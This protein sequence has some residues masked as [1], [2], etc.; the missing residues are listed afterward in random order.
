MRLFLIPMC[1]DEW[2]E[3][4]PWAE[5]AAERATALVRRASPDS[6]IR[7]LR[8][9]GYSGKRLPFLGDGGNAA[10]A[11]F[12]W[13]RSE[14]DSIVV[15][16]PRFV[17][18]S[19]WTLDR[20]LQLIDW[21]ERLVVAVRRMRAHIA[22]R[23]RPIRVQRMVETRQTQ[24]EIPADQELMVWIHGVRSGAVAAMG[25]P[26]RFVRPGPVAEFQLGDAEPGL[27]E[28]TPSAE[29]RR[30]T[31]RFIWRPVPMVDGY[32]VYLGGPGDAGGW[33]LFQQGIRGEAEWDVTRGVMVDPASGAP[34]TGR[35]QYPAQYESAGALAAFRPC[36][37][38]ELEAMYLQGQARAVVMDG[39]EAQEVRTALDAMQADLTN[40]RGVASAAE[41]FETEKVLGLKA[42][43]KGDMEGA[44][45]AFCKAHLEACRGGPMTRERIDPDRA[46]DEGLGRIADSRY[47]PSGT[48]VRRP[49]RRR[50]AFVTSFLTD[51]GGHPR[52]LS[53]VLAGLRTERYEVGVF[54]TEFQS[55]E[56]AGPVA[57]SELQALPAVER[58]VLIPHEGSWLEAADRL[59]EALKEFDPDGICLFAAPYDTI[60][61]VV[62]R[63]LRRPTLYW[64]AAPMYPEAGTHL[65]AD[66]LI[67]FPGDLPR[68]RSWLGSQARIG[69]FRGGTDAGRQSDRVVPIS[70]EELYARHHLNGTDGRPLVSVT[71]GAVYKTLYGSTA[72]YRALEEILSR[73]PDLH[74]YIIGPHGTSQ[75]DFFERW[76]LS[77][78]SGVASRVCMTGTIRADLWRYLKRA[79]LYLDSFPM[80]GGYSVLEAMQFGK[81]VIT[82]RP[83]ADR[84]E[85]CPAL[86]FIDLEAC[87]ARDPRDY[88]VKSVSMLRSA[89]LRQ[90]VGAELRRRASSWDLEAIAGY[91]DGV[92]MRWLDGKPLEAVG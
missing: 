83:P 20:A 23:L 27:A 58:I 47:P 70:D 40:G 39:E 71:V 62:A 3:A 92:F 37:I 10:L 67:S 46:M 68:Y 30:D 21:G 60:A 87:V 48:R 13:G 19:A 5:G 72:Y 80:G 82:L 50:I 36:G 12:S 26:G 90:S 76:R 29:W 1:E 73:V 9:T 33:E 14:F 85:L 18:L 42:L 86:L 64:H 49:G 66:H 69:L 34:I 6:T 91:Y 51:G 16:D 2:K 38:E 54:S 35:Q 41:R 55:S 74:H 24:I 57:L 79:D 65:F 17:R 43:E 25:R 15:M 11:A 32:R 88:F 56:K 4:W 89:A 75:P 52:L 7:V 77:L 8:V 78:P 81:P 53:A 31:V 22:T 28:L 63:G 59:M 45:R 44:L 84:F 61:V